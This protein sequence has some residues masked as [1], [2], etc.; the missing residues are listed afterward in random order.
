MKI[1]MGATPRNAEPKRHW[2]VNVIRAFGILQVIGG[3]FISYFFLQR[4]IQVLLY[5]M[6]MPFDTASVVAMLLAIVLGI[7]AGFIMAAMTFAVA[8]LIDDMHTVRGYLSD[9]QITGKYYD[10]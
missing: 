5:S 4:S 1:V 9:M 10:E 3:A 8:M 2:T 7:F 6:G